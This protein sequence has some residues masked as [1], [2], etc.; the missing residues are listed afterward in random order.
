MVE[1]VMYQLEA[2]VFVSTFRSLHKMQ[3]CL[4]G[5]IAHLLA[6]TREILSIFLDALDKEHAMVVTRDGESR[7]SHHHRLMEPFFITLLQI[8]GLWGVGI[9]IEGGRD[10]SII[11]IESLQIVFC[12]HQ[13]LCIAKQGD[14]C[15]RVLGIKLIKLVENLS[16]LWRTP[17]IQDY[18]ILLTWQ[19]SLG[20]LVYTR[21]YIGDAIVDV[22][23]LQFLSEP[24]GKG[25]LARSGV[26]AVYED[27]MHIG[28]PLQER[29]DGSIVQGFRTLI[30]LKNFLVTLHIV[31][32]DG[33]RN[34]KSYAICLAEPCERSHLLGIEWTKDDVT[35]VGALL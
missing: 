27:W 18:D 8:F 28:K 34:H 21:V 33:E 1:R 15:S 25:T 4:H 13:P 17:R 19:E 2:L 9:I 10:I 32:A 26:I 7:L 24:K 30:Y 12:I 5:L 22:A 16:E 29:L 6:L 23:F 20:K 14:G 11:L 3:W 31:T 35:L